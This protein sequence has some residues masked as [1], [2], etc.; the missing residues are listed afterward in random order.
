MAT[1]K[2]FSFLSWFYCCCC[3]WLV[4]FGR[5]PTDDIHKF[6]YFEYIAEA[7]RF[8]SFIQDFIFLHLVVLCWNFS[9]VCWRWREARSGCWQKRRRRIWTKKH[10]YKQ[11]NFLFELKNVH[12][13]AWLEDMCVRV[14]ASA[15]CYR[16]RFISFYA[17]R[18][19]QFGCVFF[20]IMIISYSS[21]ARTQFL[22]SSA[23]NFP[24]GFSSL[25]RQCVC[26]HIYT[27]RAQLKKPSKCVNGNG[28]K[29]HT[30]PAVARTHLDRS[31]PHIES[32]MSPAEE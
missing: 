24:L 11:T 23:H 1:W 26:A 8:E 31:T 14:S 20:H 17:L 32:V 27:H 6:Y 28:R 10:F 15:H 18:F 21:R 25:C 7:K 9:F 16:T 12:E 30:P 5:L 22:L 19:E 13:H 4:Y 2:S 3:C 29:K